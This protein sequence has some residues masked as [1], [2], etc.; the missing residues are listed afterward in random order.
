METVH[1]GRAAAL[2]RVPDWASRASTASAGIEAPN[3]AGKTTTVAILDGSR[4]RG[5]GDVR[6]LGEGPALAGRC[7]RARKHGWE[8]RAAR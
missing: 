1:F 7:W 6:V 4:R 2:D 5:T 3:G 8:L